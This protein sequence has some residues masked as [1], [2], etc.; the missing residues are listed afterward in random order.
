M[1]KN[2]LH[3]EE[4]KSLFAQILPLSLDENSGV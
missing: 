3:I 2:A 4:I 1:T